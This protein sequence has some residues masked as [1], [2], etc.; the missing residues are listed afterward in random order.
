[1]PLPSAVYVREG[2]LPPRGARLGRVPS[3]PF[4]RLPLREGLLVTDAILE[5]QDL[6][7]HFPV[8]RSGIQRLLWG[9]KFAVH[10]IDGVSFDLRRGEIFGLV[11]E[12]GCGKTTVG[13]TV[14]RLL[15]PT[16][17][18]IRFEGTDITHVKEK[19]L[20]DTRKAM[21]L[22]FQDPH[23]SLNPGMSIGQSIAD[24]LM[25][26]GIATEQKAKKAA[27]DIMTEVG[28]SP[29]EQ[30]YGKYPADLSGGQKQRA[31]IARAM[32]LKPKFVVADEPVAMLDMSIRAKILEL[33][34]QLKEKY[35]LTYLFITHDLATAKLICD[36]IAIMYLGQVVEVGDAKEI[37]HD[38]KHP[39]TRALL[40][41]IP[42]PDPDRRR[43]KTIPKGEVP[44]AIYP[45]EGGRF[46]PRCPVAT[47]TCGWEP[48][49]LLDLLDQRALDEATRVA[50]E[51]HLVPRDRMHVD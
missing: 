45:P 8:R 19:K 13:R 42:I 9:R 20:R 24:P 6:V 29:A 12:S 34:L 38:P 51:G 11:G 7:K 50:D 39:Y 16:S 10:A 25:I 15:E 22:I 49:D 18:T 14:L 2:N 35:G 48:R 30:L 44:D 3:W 21:Q 31:V 1:M 41:A 27:L 40:G 43:F 46:H 4:R 5:V 47:N 37:F 23:A 28:L 26:H 36:R 32:I 33:M 17:G